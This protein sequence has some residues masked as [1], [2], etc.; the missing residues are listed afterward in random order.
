[1]DFRNK[2]LNHFIVGLLS[3]LLVLLFHSSGISLIRAT[4]GTAFVLL[5]LTLIIGPIMRL[6]Q[7]ALAGLPWDLPWSW[8]GELGI[9]FTILAITHVS[10]IFSGKHWDIAGYLATMRIS[11]LIGLVA[12]FFALILAATSF[13]KVVKFLGILSWRWLHSFAY[14]IFY[15]VGLH[16][17]NHAFFRTGRPA[18]WLHWIYLV[19][20]IIVI[21]LQFAAFIKTV[22]N[23]R[24]TVEKQS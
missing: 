7:P 6:W 5:F 1:M 16:T 14:V 19:L 2:L 4:A 21:F 18:N 11:D 22:I 15:L 8:R 23:Y 24:K 3:L 12:L 17:I 20:M 10:L 13:G 9:W